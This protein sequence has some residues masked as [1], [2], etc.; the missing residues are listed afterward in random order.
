MTTEPKTV[1]TPLPADSWL[2]AFM[3]QQA[4]TPR[5]RIRGSTSSNSR[6]PVNRL[7]RFSGFA[8]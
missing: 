1:L 5:G 7:T 6:A 8:R 3:S 2:L 4:L